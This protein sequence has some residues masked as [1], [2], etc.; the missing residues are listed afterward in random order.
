MNKFSVFYD[1]QVKIYKNSSGGAYGTSAEKSFLKSISADVQPLTLSL[2]D[3]E[4]GLSP[5]VKAKMFFALTDSDGVA[6][7]D[8]AETGG[9]EYRITGLQKRGLGMCAVLESFGENS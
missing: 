9:T 2:S 6:V 7:G 5:N 4:Y 8:C 3:R 1:S